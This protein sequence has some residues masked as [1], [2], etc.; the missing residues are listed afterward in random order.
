M[1]ADSALVR[2]RG[3]SRTHGRGDAARAVVDQVDLSIDAGE[4]VAVVGSS[5]SGKSTLLHLIG[6]LDD[7][8]R[9]I[10]RGGGHASRRALP[11]AASRAFAATRS[12]SSSR[13]SSS[14]PSS[15]PGRTSCCPYGSHTISDAGRRRR[16]PTLFDRLGIAPLARRLPGDLAGGEQQRVA[17]A[18]AL[19]MQPR[20]VLADEPTGNLDATAGNGVL[21]LLLRLA[22]TPARAVVMV[23]HDDRHAAT[24][25]RVVRL[26]RR[27]SRVR[28][29]LVRALAGIRARPMSSAVAALGLFV[30]G[31]I[32]GG[33]ITTRRRAR[34][35]VR[36]RPAR[37]G[38]RRRHRSLRSGRAQR[39]RQARREP[40]QRRRGVSERLT[41]RP[42]DMGVLLSANHPRYGTAEVDGLM[43]GT[44]R[45]VST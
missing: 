21:E 2:V 6:G 27:A 45:R 4:M 44:R 42:V 18:R 12:G 35:R 1:E 31:A 10:G 29:P 8:T 43:P 22:V 3:L 11:D 14:C 23:T 34:E 20:L 32:L 39:G 9:G 41:V 19:V 24:A 26:A 5:G 7:P 25:D 16:R 40:R 30:A 28:A 15:A 38:Q 36:P 33:A 37:R 13:P 17:I